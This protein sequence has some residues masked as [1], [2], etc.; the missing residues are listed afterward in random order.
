MGCSSLKSKANDR[1]R[2]VLSYQI[3]KKKEKMLEEK[4]KQNNI[5]RIKFHKKAS[6]IRKIYQTNGFKI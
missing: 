4:N 2:N 1:G 3:W 5:C 6:K